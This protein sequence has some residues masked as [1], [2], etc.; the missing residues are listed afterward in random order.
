M[1]LLENINI[2][3]SKTSHRGVSLNDLFQ[4]GR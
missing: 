2:A 3:V 4:Q 1:K